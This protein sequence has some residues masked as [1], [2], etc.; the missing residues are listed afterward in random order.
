MSIFSKVSQKDVPY[1]TF[2]MSYDRK[3]SLNMGDLVPMHLQE[4]IPGDVFN[5]KTQ[6]ILRL[7]PL[8]SPMMH[9]VNVFTH[10]FFVPSRLLWEGWEDFITGGKDGLDIQLP[11]VSSVTCSRGSLGDYLG[12]PINKECKDIS[13]LPFAAYQM[14]YNEYYRD[15]NLI[16]EI[17]ITL[18]D[19]TLTNAAIVAELITLR[20]R[21]W[22]HDYFTSALPFAQK[23]EAVKLP[24]IGASAAEYLDVNFQPNNRASIIRNTDGTPRGTVADEPLE[25]RNSNFSADLNPVESEHV[26]M[27]NAAQLKVPTEQM[28]SIGST[29]TDLRRAYKLQ[30]WL[31]KAARSGSRYKENILAFFGVNTSDGRMQRPEYL[32]G[33]MSP[34]MVSEVLQTSETTTTPQGNMAGH[35]LNLGGGHSFERRFEEH[36]FVI[37]I[38]S[39]MPKSA[40]QEGI[41]RMW[42]RNDKF[43]FFWPQFQHIGEQEILNKELFVSGDSTTDNSV[44]GYIP[45]YAEYKYNSSSVHGYFKDNLDFWHLGRIF[46]STPALNK[47]FIEC[48]PSRRV[49]AVTDPDEHILYCQ[50]FHQIEAKRKM[51]YYADPKFL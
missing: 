51:A 39:V 23:G 22:N 42:N 49:F 48:N 38:V 41:N 32:G 31:E 27:D 17:D 36:G 33:G 2:N 40:Y 25:N 37:G 15:Q 34:V 9:E 29:I 6:Q 43:D 4:V 3:F 30:E 13:L 19:G 26:A 10:F 28:T 44:F 21:A 11:P 5:H 1:S 16:D 14:I 46:E 50:M 18:S 47:E 7:A 12:L 35:G 24:L 8:V 45:R 20:K